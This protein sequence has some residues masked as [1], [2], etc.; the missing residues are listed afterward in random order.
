MVHDLEGADVDVSRDAPL[1][2]NPLPTCTNIP[3]WR[4]LSAAVRDYR[5]NTL[6]TARLALQARNCCLPWPN[7]K[8]S[9]S[10]SRNEGFCM[11]IAIGMAL[12]MVWLS[13]RC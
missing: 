4:N 11:S 5:A 10:I 7:R 8:A 9:I 6:T 1:L 13:T 12:I 3:G 2:M